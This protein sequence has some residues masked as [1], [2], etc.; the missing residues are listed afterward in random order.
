MR[1]V[2]V[3]ASP[4]SA[5]IQPLALDAEALQAMLSCQL[6]GAIDSAA[7]AKG[8]V[9][10]GLE[11]QGNERIFF[12]ENDGETDDDLD[13]WRRAAPRGRPL[14]CMLAQHLVA[15][16]GGRVAVS[17]CATGERRV[18]LRLPA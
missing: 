13:D 18:E 9:V 17:R 6:Y 7:S 1:G 12:V 16:R 15:V 14:A 3:I 2:R 5:D 11:C 4:V 10:F 8:R